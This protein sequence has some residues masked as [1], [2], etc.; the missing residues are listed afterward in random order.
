MTLRTI[1]WS[2][3]REAKAIG[4]ATAVCADVA[5][6]YEHHMPWLGSVTSK[7]LSSIS[8]GVYYMCV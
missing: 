1:H 3:M 7:V 8:V 5:G 6:V 2:F 4:L